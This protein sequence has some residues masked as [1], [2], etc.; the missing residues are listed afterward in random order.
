[1]AFCVVVLPV[2]AVTVNVTLAPEAGDP[3]LVTEAA[4]GTVPGR[5]KFA[6]ESERLTTTDGGVVTVAFAVSVVLAAGFDA[7]ILTA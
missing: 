5:V 4:I 7:L 3:L 2:G 1:M 6:A